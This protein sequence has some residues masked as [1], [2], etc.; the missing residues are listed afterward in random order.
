[1]HG[2][3]RLCRGLSS[4]K[5]QRSCYQHTVESLSGRSK[6]SET[7]IIISLRLSHR[8]G[9]DTRKFVAGF[10]ILVG[11]VTLKFTGF[12]GPLIGCMSR[13]ERAIG[14]WQLSIA[15]SGRFFDRSHPGPHYTLYSTYQVVQ[16]NTHRSWPNQLPGLCIVYSIVI[17]AQTPQ[18]LCVPV[19]ER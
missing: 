1:M 17:L 2:I 10:V 6:Y 9:T 11:S 4:E 8:P 14:Q 3:W 7:I 16:S 15:Y 19:V 18:L 5:R 12:E 13:R